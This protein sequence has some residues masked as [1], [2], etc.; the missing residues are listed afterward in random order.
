MARKSDTLEA[1]RQWWRGRTKGV[2]CKEIP[3][4]DAMRAAAIVMV[5]LYHERADTA[6]GW[7]GVTMFFVLSGFLITR[8]LLQEVNRSGTISLPTFYKRRSMR[9]LPSVLPLL[10]Y[11]HSHHARGTSSRSSGSRPP[12][13]FCI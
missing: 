7:L 11:H 8:L 5:V 9:N 2:P 6:P 1:C 10:D 13:R 3:G 4:L 12:S